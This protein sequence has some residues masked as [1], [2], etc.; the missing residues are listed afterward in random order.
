[1]GYS[2]A[3]LAIS[4]TPIASGVAGVLVGFTAAGTNW[5][6]YSNDET[7]AMTTTT[8]TGTIAKNANW[9][10]IEINWTASGNVDVIFDGTT[11]TLS[12][13]IPLTTSN[14]YFQ[15]VGQTSAAT[16]RTFSIHSVWIECDK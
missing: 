2:G 14:L 7:G 3:A 9:H 5:E 4:D 16:A 6:I 15:C 8:V 1:V 12:S 11:Q 10:T 13:N